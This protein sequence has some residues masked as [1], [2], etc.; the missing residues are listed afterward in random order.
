LLVMTC[1][2]PGGEILGVPGRIPNDGRVYLHNQRMGK[3][4]VTEPDDLDAGFLYYLFLSQP[5]NR[6]LCSTATGSKI[7]HTAPKRIE[8]YRFSRPPLPVQRRIASILSAYDDLIENNTKRIKVLE[9]MAQALCREWFVHFRFPGHEKVELVDSSM[10]QIPDGWCP[11]TIGDETTK[12]GS[13][14][15]PKGGKGAYTAAGVTLIRS[16]N[17]YDYRFDDDGLAFIDEE[18]AANLD[19]VTVE[20]WDVLLN[21]TGAS[22][23]RCCMVPRRH[24]PARVNQHV[25]IIRANPDRIDPYYLL[26]SINNDEQK[27]QLLAFAQGG[28]TREALTKA[29]IEKFPLLVP[30]RSVIERFGDAAGA[31][32]RQREVL[33]HINVTLRQTRDLLLPHLIS[34]V[35]DVSTLPL[36]EST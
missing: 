31:F 32:L 6:H 23:A 16:M 2:T 36:P 3:L 14:A 27:R 9:E 19:G 21:I 34:G 26:C 11:S 24:L 22:V 17:V 20:P 4:V 10:G 30:E 1:Q 8:A 28:A 33:E 18:Q 7:L 13:G 25:A 5:F 29:T 15:T 12:V 35:L